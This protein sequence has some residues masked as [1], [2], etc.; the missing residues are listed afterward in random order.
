MK[1]ELN[2]MY[3][4]EKF[5]NQIDC[6]NSINPNYPLRKDNRYLDIYCFPDGRIIMH[7]YYDYNYSYSVFSIKWEPVGD[8]EELINA[9]LFDEWSCLQLYYDSINKLGFSFEEQF[10]AFRLKYFIR[11]GKVRRYSPTSV[12]EL[13]SEYESGIN[14]GENICKSIRSIYLDNKLTTDE[15][16]F[17]K[18]QRIHKSIIECDPREFKTVIVPIERELSSMQHLVFANENIRSLFGAC[19]ILCS[20]KYNQ[21]FHL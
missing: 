20:E 12:F 16:S 8:Y 7:G 14:V 9:V 10:S 3:S 1:F 19:W 2:R 11:D 18:L 17:D 13:I 15:K 4:K 6:I 21:S 5:T